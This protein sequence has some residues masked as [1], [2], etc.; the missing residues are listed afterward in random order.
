MFMADQHGKHPDSRIG[1]GRKSYSL[2]F[3][4]RTWLGRRHTKTHGVRQPNNEAMQEE[5]QLRVLSCTSSKWY[6]S[7]KVKSRWKLGEHNDPISWTCNGRIGSLIILQIRRNMPPIELMIW[8]VNCQSEITG[9]QGLSSNPKLSR[10]A[11]KHPGT[12]FQH[13]KQNATKNSFSSPWPTDQRD[14]QIH[15][16]PLWDVGTYCSEVR[17]TFHTVGNS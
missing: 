10:I 17:V 9:S 16:L 5:Q 11:P 12:F 13:V 15:A 3:A 1:I 6:S 4:E 14:Y 8:V 2:Q 7:S